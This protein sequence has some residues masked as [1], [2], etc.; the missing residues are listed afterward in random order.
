MICYPTVL[1]LCQNDLGLDVHELKYLFTPV[2]SKVR[3]RSVAVIRA[4]TGCSSPDFCVPFIVCDCFHL[5]LG[6]VPVKSVSGVMEL[7]RRAPAML[8]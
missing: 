3:I 4:F 5:I 2:K 1:L 7:E 8:V 6:Q